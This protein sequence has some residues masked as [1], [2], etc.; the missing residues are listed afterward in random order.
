VDVDSIHVVVSKCESLSSQNSL[1]TLVSVFPNP[2]KG[3]VTLL[4]RGEQSKEVD[5][6]VF[7]ISGK[8]VL[9]QHLVFRKDKSESHINLSSCESGY[10]FICVKSGQL[11]VLR[12]PI[13]KE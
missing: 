11:P 13:F 2:S 6:E 9:S 12:V 7:D 10:Y 8:V 4:Y 1:S 5:V 3:P